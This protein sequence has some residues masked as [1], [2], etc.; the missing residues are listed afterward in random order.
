MTTENTMQCP[1][2]GHQVA[3]DARFCGKCGERLGDYRAMRNLPPAELSATKAPWRSL[4]RTVV[5]VFGWVLIVGYTLTS[6]L[7]VIRE[8]APDLMDDGPPG[9]SVASQLSENFQS[10]PLSSQLF[11]NGMFVSIGAG[12]VFATRRKDGP[13]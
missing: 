1:E 6:G 2:C 11:I 9:E 8:V 10:R 5:K 7:G 3:Y 12:L 13:N 4:I